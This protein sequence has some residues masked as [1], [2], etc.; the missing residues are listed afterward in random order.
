MM[1]VGVVALQRNVARTVTVSQAPPAASSIM[2][3]IMTSVYGA[4]G[5]SLLAKPR[6]PTRWR[7]TG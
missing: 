7:A 6:V 5:G 1:P 4:L 3:A 2:L